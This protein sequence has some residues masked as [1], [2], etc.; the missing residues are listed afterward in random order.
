M[1]SAPPL[2]PA[3][4][5]ELI[6]LPAVLTVPGDAMVGAA[7]S[8]S[9][10]GSALAAGSA[11]VYAGGMALNDYADRRVDALERPGRPVP[12]GRVTAAQARSVATR[13]LL[14]GVVASRLLGGPA[15][16][17]VAL[18][19]VVSVVGYDARAKGGRGGPAVMA[20]CRGLDVLL[21]AAGAGAKGL[22]AAMPAAAVVAAHTASVTALSAAEVDGADVQLLRDTRRRVLAV[23]AAVPVL[24]LPHGRRAIALAAAGS[25]VYASHCTVALARAERDT[26]PAAAQRAV[27]ACVL[28]VVP[29]Q[30][31]LLAAH[32]S[33]LRAAAVLALLPLAR[34]AARRRSVT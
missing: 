23:A 16:G 14:A 8:R 17:R 12:S 22:A 24:A 9:A 10:R 1:T 7:S 15:A 26:S 21:G 30:S 28:G 31:A 19:L 4:L 6:R 18:A 5:A 34:S 33:R 25:A 32:G 2:S 27:G 13:L 11:L 20:A 29:L 3:L